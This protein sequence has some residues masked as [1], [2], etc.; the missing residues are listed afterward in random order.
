M[1]SGSWWVTVHGVTESWTQLSNWACML[2]YVTRIS[3]SLAQPVQVVPSRCSVSHHCAPL[4]PHTPEAAQLQ[5]I[6]DGPCWVG[7]MG[8]MP[9]NLLCNMR[10]EGGPNEPRA[11]LSLVSHERDA[12][13]SRGASGHPRM[14]PFPGFLVTLRTG[15]SFPVSLLLHV[16]ILT[17]PILAFL[18]LWPAESSDLSR[19]LA[20]I[21]SQSFLG[22]MSLNWNVYMYWPI[23]Q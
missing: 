18:W 4:V 7:N 23:S 17:P 16:S 11:H 1:D 21:H 3:R 22:H 19:V 6:R 13:S 14:L 8:T 10:R 12:S 5:L 2:A 15:A 20:S 9:E